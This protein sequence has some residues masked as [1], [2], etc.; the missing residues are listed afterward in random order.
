MSKVSSSEV[1]RLIEGGLA[2]DDR[3]KV[4]FVNDFSFE[5]VKRCYMVSNHRVGFVRAWHAHHREAKYVMVVKGEAI[6]AAVAIDDWDNPA[7]DATINRYILSEQKPAV[8]Y[9]PRAY[10]NGFMTLSPDTRMMYFST[11]SLEESQGDDI[12]Y[13]A[14]YWDPWQVEER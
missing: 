11:S 7:K 6:V 3:G 9:I 12:R 4:A 10:A 2:V 1:P 13:H 14:R 8:L 5:D